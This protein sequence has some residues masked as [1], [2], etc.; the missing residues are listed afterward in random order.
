MRPWLKFLLLGANL[1]ILGTVHSSAVAKTAG[2]CQECHSQKFSRS[3][4][5]EDRSVFQAKLDPC[6]GVRTLGEEIFFTESRLLKLNQI[7]QA[8]EGEGWAGESWKQKIY[9]A[10][11][12]FSD[13]KGRKKTSLQQFFQESAVL[14]AALQ[15]VYE[16][17]L[18]GRN[19]SARRWLIGLGSLIFLGVLVLLGIGYRKLQGMGKTLLLLL[20]IGGSLSF[21]SC[22]SGL[23][24]PEKKSPAQ[25]RLDQALSVATRSISRMEETFSLSLLL[26]EMAGE[27]SKIEPGPAEKAFQL[28]W[29]MTLVA[30]EQAGQTKSLGGIVSRWPD[31]AEAVKQKVNFDTVLDLREEL[32]NADPRAW[33]LRAVAE[34]WVEANG[35]KGRM[36][37]EFASKEA[38]AMKDAELRDRDLKTIAEA[39]GRIDKGRALQIARSVGDPF[40][41]AVAL[42]EA[43]FSTIHL[44]EAWKAAELISSQYPQI[45]AFIQISAVAAR[46]NPAEKNTWAEK[47]FA[48]TKNLKNQELH[49]L[50]IQEMVMA[51]APLD[52]E[53]AERWA[54]GI[55]PDFPAARGYAFIHLASRSTR[56]PKDKAVSLLKGA[57]VEA[58]R[59]PD[60]YEAQKVQRLAVQS[61]GQLEP[62]EALRVIPEV[63]NP[64]YRSE[65]LGQLA[66]R[67]SREDKRKGLD[68][69][70]KIPLDAFRFRNIVEIIGQWMPGDKD[71][72]TSIYREA[73]QAASSISDP[74]ARCLNLIDL[75]KNW[76]QW[77]RERGA[78]VLNLAFGSL[79]KIDSPSK[80]V[81]ILE[82]LAEAWKNFDKTKTRN[83]LQ[84]IDHSVILARKSLEE[85]RFWA[86]I[87]PM[88]AHQWAES[89]PSAFPLEKAA[90]FK[91]VAASM[92]KD[93]PG[94]A[95]DVL[96]KALA[97]AMPLSEGSKRNKLLSQLIVEAALLDK[98]RTLCRLREMEDRETKDLLLKE[99][100]NALIKENPSWAMKAAGEISESSLRFPLYQKIAEEKAK[101]RPASRLDRGNEPALIALFHWGLGREKAKSNESQAIPLYE[102][103]LQEIGKVAEPR[104]QSYLLGALAADWASIDE[105][106][107][108]QA[109]EKISADFPEPFSYALLQVG[110]Q[111]RRWTRERAEMVFNKTL[112]SA[113]QIPDL[114]LRAKR[115][116]QLAQQWGAL[117]GEKGK[118]VLKKAESEARKSVPRPGSGKAEKIL[119]E[120]LVAKATWEPGEAL[121]MA[122]NAGQPSL[123]AKILLESAKVLSKLHMEQNIKALD[124]SLQFA[125]VS[126]NHPL[127]SQVAVAWFALDPQKGLELLAQAEPKEV[128]IEAL[129]RMAKQCGS[130]R[131]EEANRLLQQA[132]QEA[133]GIDGLKERVKTLRGIAG[134]WA[135]IDKGRAK[136]TYLQAYDMV[137]KAFF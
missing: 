73:F 81:E 67:L 46:M 110:T 5:V 3:I 120:I 103:A 33:A 96:E 24:E 84:G 58:S 4:A 111:L 31:R 42:I 132:T 34:E 66:R 105:E 100:G 91:E 41:K 82:M 62:E 133:L 53:R 125:Q 122:K 54:A 52:W 99:V 106:K 126:K 119:T 127:L 1:A 104:D 50:A 64:Y 134:D 116:F 20:L 19:E 94:L 14:R 21:I 40:L 128:R 102:Q 89:I 11:E 109:A 27:W 49:T 72:I 13:L 78:A 92:K 112:S 77:E 55:A 51:W 29:Q 95:F 124:K 47:I 80:K 8:M 7:L 65:I 36:A 60:S 2:Y 22:S 101:L 136:V 37:L 61:L 135:G 25:E 107:A 76:G 23:T 83:I 98:E 39:W 123:R 48:K 18:Q 35:K 59:V 79:G 86:K 90:A 56:I 108:L 43:S 97:Q 85:I 117:N 115:L 121:T 114:S 32:R 137:K 28:A 12:S 129:R 70:G 88:K 74:Y 63:E 15:K 10:A 30:R 131:K 17:T 9:E 71:K 26:T 44:Q 130:E 45:K 118:E 93:Q 68:L 16:H 57:I 38:L 113:F 75:A 69:A 87:D 6:P